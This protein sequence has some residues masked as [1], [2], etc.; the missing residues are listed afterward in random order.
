MNQGNEVLIAGI[1]ADAKQEEE[2]ILAEAG[3]QA[4]DKLKYGGQKIESVLADA[5]QRAGKQAD[6]IKRKALSAVE[7]EVRRRSLRLRDTVT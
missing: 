5:R 3:Q 4:A 7:M 1:E 2:K 6:E